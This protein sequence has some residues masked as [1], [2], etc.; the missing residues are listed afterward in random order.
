MLMAVK[1]ELKTKASHF[2]DGLDIQIVVSTW[3]P[4]NTVVLK[5]LQ[6]TTRSTPARA[7]LQVA[8]RDNASSEFRFE[9]E[10]VITVSGFERRHY[11]CIVESR[12]R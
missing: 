11:H 5:Q 8:A 9:P 2:R 10:V 1:P 3:R 4:M 12:N 7:K 6:A